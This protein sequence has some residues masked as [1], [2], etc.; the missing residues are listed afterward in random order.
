MKDWMRRRKGLNRAAIARVETT[1]ASCGCCSWPVRVRKSVWCRRHAPEVDRTSSRERAVDEG[2][3]DDDVYVVEAVLQDGEAHGDRDPTKL[4]SAAYC[5]SLTTTVGRAAN[6]PSAGEMNEATMASG[7]IRPDHRSGEGYP[8]D[9]LALLSPRSPVAQH[10]AQR[11]GEHA[12]GQQREE[13][14]GGNDTQ[15]SSLEPEGI[16][17]PSPGLPAARGEGDGKLTERA[18]PRK[19]RPGDATSSRVASR[20]GTARTGRSRGA[21]RPVHSHVASA[22]DRHREREPSRGWP[23]RRRRSRR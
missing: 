12:Q 11:R 1:T 19:A 7:T 20:R 15:G 3:V 16:A 22:R 6:Q 21:P 13:D 5:R 23:A 8:L 10:Q 17:H 4:I 14:I 9:L 18:P 2:A